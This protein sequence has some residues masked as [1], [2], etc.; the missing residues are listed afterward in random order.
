MLV[1]IKNKLISL[2]GSSQV[3]NE[4]KELVFNVKGKIFSPTRKKFIYDKEGNLLYIIRNKF[5]TFF[6]NRVYIFDAEKNRIATIKKSK[7]SFNRNYKIEDTED[8]MSIG[9]KFFST[10]STILKNDEP[11]GVIQRKI[12]ALTDSSSIEEL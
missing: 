10:T 11:V 1:Y 9:G 12:L 5:W 8:A 6:A 4:D 3:L 2:G 7:F